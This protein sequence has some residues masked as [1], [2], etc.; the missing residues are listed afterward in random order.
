MLS[1]EHWDGKLFL[2]GWNAA[3]KTRDVIAPGSGEKLTRVGIA[4]PKDVAEATQRAKAAQRGW[5]ALPYE[6]RATIF[7]KAADIVHR[8]TEL[9]TSWI[10]RETGGIPP[11]A[12][13]ELHMAHGILLEAASLL[14]QPSGL[15][16]PSN[17]GRISLAR[18]VPHGVVGVISPFNFPL[19][20]SI[21]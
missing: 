19:I 5:V 8:E 6:E 21:R 15:L 14:T 9:M 4:T 12:G 18:R 2:S 11:K 20:L 16:L 10:V 13:V 1:T 17:G 3:D 7:R